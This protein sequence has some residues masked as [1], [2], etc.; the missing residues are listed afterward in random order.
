MKGEMGGEVGREAALVGN[1]YGDASCRAYHGELR[2]AIRS[3]EMA[4]RL[5]G[6][7]EVLLSDAECEGG[8]DG[9]RVRV[10]KV[11]KMRL[12]RAML[13]IVFAGSPNQCD[14]EMCKELEESFI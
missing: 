13:N 10:G 5:N 6:S 1:G 12:N 4:Q 9:K 7:V 11:N 14:P 8:E 3:M 2:R